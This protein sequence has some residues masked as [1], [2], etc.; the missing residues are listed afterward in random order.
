MSHGL[1]TRGGRG[2]QLAHEIDD[3]RCRAS[4]KADAVQDR[5]HLRG[6]DGARHTEQVPFTIK[7]QVHEKLR[8]ASLTHTGK[9]SGYLIDRVE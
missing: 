5:G 7:R 6:V 8:C 2:I 1:H 4:R 9:R 3:L